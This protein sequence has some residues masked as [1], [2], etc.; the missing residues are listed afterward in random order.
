ML[1]EQ[2]GYLNHSAEIMSRTKKIIITLIVLGIIS[3]ITGLG[4]QIYKD[5]KTIST[6]NKELTYK[7]GKIDSLEKEVNNLNNRSVVPLQQY[8]DDINFMESVVWELRGEFEREC[9][10]SN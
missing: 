9:G 8:V 3:I 7:T 10:K 5:Q 6:L 2:Y 1:I 4:M